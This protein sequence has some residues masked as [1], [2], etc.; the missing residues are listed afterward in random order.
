MPPEVKT[1]SLN[2]SFEDPLVL[3]PPEAISLNIL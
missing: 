3:T 2:V 1:I